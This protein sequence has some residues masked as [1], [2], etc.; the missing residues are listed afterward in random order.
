MTANIYNNLITYSVAGSSIT[1]A[2][3]VTSMKD[4]VKKKVF[5]VNSSYNNI[6]ALCES[7]GDLYVVVSIDGHRTGGKFKQ[8][9]KHVQSI[10]DRMGGKKDESISLKDAITELLSIRRTI[11]RCVRHFLDSALDDPYLD[12]APIRYSDKSLEKWCKHI[13]DGKLIIGDTTIR[14]S[15]TLRDAI[16]SSFPP[17][18][19]PDNEKRYI[20]KLIGEIIIKSCTGN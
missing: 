6:Y 18:E 3:L 2:T 12:I 1:L 4:G 19:C 14:V 9:P 10:I 17:P 20:S 7:E 15:D 16:K 8:K 5:R 11:S 13:D